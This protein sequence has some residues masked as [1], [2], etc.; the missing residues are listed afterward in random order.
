MNL[1]RLKHSTF[2][3][4]ILME[5]LNKINCIVWKEVVKEVLY[6]Y[7]HLEIGSII[8]IMLVKLKLTT[9]GDN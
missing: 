3:S 4:T 8:I 1:I 9:T 5:W 6:F 7:L 2:V